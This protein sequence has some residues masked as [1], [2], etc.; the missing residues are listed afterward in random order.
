MAFSDLTDPTAVEAALDEFDRIG[1]D[2]FLAKYGFG[3][4]TG[5]FVERDGKRYDSKAIYGAAHG[6]QFPD[7]GPLRHEE[8]YGGEATVGRRLEGLGFRFASAADLN[9]LA[10]PSNDLLRP[11]RCAGPSDHGRAVLDRPPPTGPSCAPT[12]DHTGTR[13]APWPRATFTCPSHFLLAPAPF[14]SDRR[15]SGSARPRPCPAR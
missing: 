2:A 3:R 11:P 1:R 9:A 10:A 14:R 4:A 7:R 15:R 8:F 13:G 6:Y 5:H 12:A